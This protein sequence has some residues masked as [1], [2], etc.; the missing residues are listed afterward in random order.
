MSILKLVATTASVV[1]VVYVTHCAQKKVVQKMEQAGHYTDSEIQAARLG[2]VLT[3]TNL[4]G[5]ALD[6]LLSAVFKTH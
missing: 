1:S 4:L 6:K 2:A 5:G 3:C